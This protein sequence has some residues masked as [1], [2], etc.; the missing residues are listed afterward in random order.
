VNIQGIIPLN[1]ITT[2][3]TSG[4]QLVWTK[5]YPNE[6]ETKVLRAQALGKGER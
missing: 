6:E 5:R 3:Q 1:S 2:E 4:Y